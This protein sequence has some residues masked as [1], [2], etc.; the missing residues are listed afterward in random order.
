MSLP[1]E[2]SIAY[3]E[4]LLLGN[5]KKCSLVVHEFL[6]QNPSLIDLYEKVIKI[7]LYEVGILW[8]TNKI[9]V[10]TE[11]LATAI[12]EG[13]LN[14]L[15]EKITPYKKYNNKVVVACVENEKHQ[16][17]IKMVADVFEMHGW[18]S[19]F[20]GA[21]IPLH[22]LEKYIKEVKPDVLAISLSVYFNYSNLLKMLELFRKEF[23]DLT[24]ILGGQAFSNYNFDLPERF[25]KVIYIPDLYMLEQYILSLNNNS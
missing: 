18:E 12:T 24:I 21:G 2:F 11:H 9:S 8:E 23:P 20:L 3:L 13:I 16:V 5:R 7:S 17:G 10:A 22:E 14:E 25:S 19:F 1:N 15:F 6:S 4:N